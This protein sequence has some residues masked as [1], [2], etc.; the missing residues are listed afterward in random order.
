MLQHRTGF[1]IFNFKMFVSD[2]NK[3]RSLEGKKKN[4]KKKCIIT[5]SSRHIYCLANDDSLSMPLCD[6]LA[7]KNGCKSMVVFL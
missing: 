6:F 2:T 5:M 4:N 7:L 3:R 1:G